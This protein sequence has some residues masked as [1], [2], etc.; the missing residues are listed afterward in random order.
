MVAVNN[1]W[2]RATKGIFATVDVAINVALFAHRL[3][4]A[5]LGGS[6]QRE[7]VLVFFLTALFLAVSRS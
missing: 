6:E 4:A 5:Y 2:D 3:P 1:N 7:Q